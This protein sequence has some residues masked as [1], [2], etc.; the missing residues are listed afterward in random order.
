MYLSRLILNPRNR[1]VQ[2]ELANPYELHRSLMCSFPDGLEMPDDERVLFRVDTD[3][4]TGAPTVLMQ[5]FHQPDWGWLDDS[6]AKNYLLPDTRWPPDVFHNPATKSFELNLAEGQLLAFRLRANPTVKRQGKRHGLYR[7]GDQMEWLSRKAQR[8]GFRIVRAA[9]I[10]EDEETGWQRRAGANRRITLFA[11]LFDGLLQV[12][13]PDRM[14]GTVQRGIGSGKA[15]GFG[16]LSLAPA[17][18]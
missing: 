7:T 5:S 15:F 11:V 10:R 12:V 1:R 3:G 14:S 6:G 18:M 13:D 17:R 2:R 9:V 8:G 16:L 4:Q